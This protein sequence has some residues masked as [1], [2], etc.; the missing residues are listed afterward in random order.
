M[1]RASFPR[2]RIG[3]PVLALLCGLLDVR[4]ASAGVLTVSP[5][6]L[7]PSRATP[8]ASMRTPFLA[9]S[10]SG[11]VTYYLPLNLPAG[12]LITGLSYQHSG[13]GDGSR[14]MVGLDRVRPAAAVPFQRLYGA[15][16]T[17]N[18][19]SVWKQVW[20]QGAHQSGAVKRIQNGWKYFLSVEATSPV[21]SLTAVGAIKVYYR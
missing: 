2:W 9:G 14:T 20:V 1:S 4:A 3:L 21:P 7:L 16:W 19:G 8:Q 13:E 12:R 11:T 17:E 18:T 5:A 15:D 10:I 6:R